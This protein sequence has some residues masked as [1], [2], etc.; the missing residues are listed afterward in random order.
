MRQI[1]EQMDLKVSGLEEDCKRLQIQLQTSEQELQRCQE[2]GHRSRLESSEQIA[3]LHSKLQ[4]LQDVASATALESIAVSEQL[5]DV[6]LAY[7]QQQKDLGIFR[8]EQ[9][10]SEAELKQKLFEREEVLRLIS[11]CFEYDLLHFIKSAN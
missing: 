9:A 2:E 3:L 7:E 1:S 6:R 4:N 10:A 11:S 5:R 8:Q